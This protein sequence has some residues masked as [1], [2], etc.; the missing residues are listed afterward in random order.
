MPLSYE[1]VMVNY[2]MQ[3]AAYRIWDFTCQKVYDI[4]APAF[5]EA[6]DPGWWRSLVASVPANQEELGFP[7]IP[8][9]G[10]ADV[11]VLAANI[12]NS[13]GADLNLVADLLS[14]PAVQPTPMPE[15]EQ[16]LPSTSPPAPQ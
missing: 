9:H 8:C 10:E 7:E 2:C 3:S 16:N 1:G 14:T 13:S 6:V 12:D 4:A 15:Q 11:E 5:E